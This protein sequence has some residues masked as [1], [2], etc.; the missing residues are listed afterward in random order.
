MSKTIL[1]VDDTAFVR[2]SLTALLAQ[3]GYRV[4]GQ[5]SNGVA[6]IELAESLSPDLIT[7]DIAMPEMSGLEAAK[8]ILNYRPDAKIV[9]ISGMDQEHLM[10]E[11]IN[12]GVRDYIVKPFD[13]NSVVKTIE[14]V[15]A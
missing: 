7:M 6:A 5:A 2:E 15:L 8:K 14:K 10:M 13:S 3:A 9:M 12:A 1:V 4:V 11:A